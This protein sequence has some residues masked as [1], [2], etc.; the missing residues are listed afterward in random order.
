MTP[1]VCASCIYTGK[2]MHHRFRPKVHR[3][4]YRVASWLL[5][6]DEIEQLDKRLTLFSYNRFNI[7][8]FHQRDHGDG[9]DAPLPQQIRQLLALHHIP[10]PD[11]I[12]LL[13]YPRMFGYT[14]NPLAIYFCF[15]DQRL[16]ALVYEVSNTFGERHSYVGAVDPQV[17]DGIVELKKSV[18][19]RQQA[20]KALHVSPFFPMNC[21]YHFRIQPPAESVTLGIDLNDNSG[22]LFTAVFKGQQQAISDRLILRQS[23]L[24]PLQTLKVIAAIHW[25]ALHLWLKGITIYQH[26]PKVT[27]FSHSPAFNR[28]TRLAHGEKKHEPN[29]LHASIC[30]AAQHGHQKSDGLAGE[31]ADTSRGQSDRAAH[32]RQ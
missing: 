28:T 27:F 7:V 17:Q 14:F 30:Q 5:D 25:Q 16:I 13:C 23:L 8:S 2:L 24:L 19:V 10:A 32:K 11:S 15:R 31:T 20:D 3:F 18:Q 12:R 4:A 6:L 1:S 21:H 29:Q 22:K 26:K 9:S